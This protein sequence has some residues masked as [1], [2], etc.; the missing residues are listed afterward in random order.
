MNK[1]HLLFKV[2]NS[3]DHIGHSMSMPHQAHLEQE[4]T[5]RCVS[6]AFLTNAFCFSDKYILQ[7]LQRPL[8]GRSFL[9][10]S[11]IISLC[12]VVCAESKI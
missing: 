7:F 10:L 6:L 11:T 3:L 4:F 8:L 12:L 2:K 9:G 1:K 5:L